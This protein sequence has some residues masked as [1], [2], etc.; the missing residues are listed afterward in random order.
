MRASGSGC[1]LQGAEISRDQQEAAL[2][3]V[4]TARESGRIFARNL[5]YTATEEDITA[6]FSKFGPLTET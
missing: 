5:P 2:D 3:G 1:D 4:E 6:L